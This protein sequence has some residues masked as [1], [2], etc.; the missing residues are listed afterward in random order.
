MRFL[1]RVLLLGNLVA[2]PALATTASGR[3]RV[4]ARLAVNHFYK[5][6][7]GKRAEETC[8]VN[9]EFWGRRAEIF[10]DTAAKGDPVLVEGRLR[11]YS[12]VADGKKRSSYRVQVGTFRVLKARER[13][14]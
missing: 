7:D 6:A 12:F 1:N 4:G 10:F 14:P 9:L 13:S 11:Y 5:T 2:D 3:V 8:F